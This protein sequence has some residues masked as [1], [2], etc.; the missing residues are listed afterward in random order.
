MRAL[1]QALL[2]A[3]TVVVVSWALVSFRRGR[4]SERRRWAKGQ[5]SIDVVVTSM[6][7]CAAG[8]CHVAVRPL[9][10]G[11]PVTDVPAAVWLPKGTYALPG[12]TVTVARRGTASNAFW[13]L[14]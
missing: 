2:A 10:D 11:D 6:P 3:F 5:H 1:R 8:D 13:E 7:R 12:E 9:H 4:L 14:T